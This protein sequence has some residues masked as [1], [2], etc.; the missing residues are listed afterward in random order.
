MADERNFLLGY[1]ERL[2]ERIPPII[3]GAPKRLPYSVPEARSRLAPLA[4]AAATELS[5]LPQLACPRDEAVA[6]ITLHPQFIAKSYY[7]A[8]YVDAA[9]V[10]FKSRH[11]VGGRGVVARV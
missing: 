4:V 5:R 11:D 9:E 8:R 6:I 2:T 1:G 7:P 10:F 3:G